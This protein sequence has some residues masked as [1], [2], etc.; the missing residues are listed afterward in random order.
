MYRIVFLLIFL[1]GILTV[2][3][4]ES[5]FILLIATGGGFIYLSNRIIELD[6]RV[7]KME[8]ELDYTKYRIENVEKTNK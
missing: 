5:I 1:V 3:F 4:H 8:H 2:A 6:N 7:R